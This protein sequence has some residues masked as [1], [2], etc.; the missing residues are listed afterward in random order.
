MNDKKLPNKNLSIEALIDE[1]AEMLVNKN[2]KL[3]VA[4]SCTGGMLAQQCTAR[5][6]STKWFECGFVTYSNASKTSILG[7]EVKVLSEHGAVSLQVA[8]QM[9]M[10]VLRNCDA[11]ISASI[12]GIAGPSGGSKI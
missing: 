10:G 3:A 6:G 4:E 9:A 11:D 8:E 7:V 2:L 1:L 12:T 5:S